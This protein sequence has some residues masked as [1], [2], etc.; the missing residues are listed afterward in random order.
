VLRFPSTA[1]GSR[2]PPYSNVEGESEPNASTAA[3]ALQRPLRFRFQARLS[4]GVR[5]PPYS[6]YA[7]GNLASADGVSYDAH[8]RRRRDDAEKTR[9]RSVYTGLN[10][11]KLSYGVT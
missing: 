11:E 9:V 5:L 6:P 7:A 4:A 2:E 1:Q 8:K 3:D 10:R